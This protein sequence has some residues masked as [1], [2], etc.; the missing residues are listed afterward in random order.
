MMADI[1]V[2]SELTKLRSELQ[3]LVDK[4]NELTR[5][6]QQVANDI[7]KKQGAIEALEKLDGSKNG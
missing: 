7:I 1:S 4:F 3:L 5:Q 2:K 6:R